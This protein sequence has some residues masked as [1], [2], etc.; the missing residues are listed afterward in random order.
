MKDE[1]KHSIQIK[2]D[3]SKNYN[4]HAATGA[5]GGIGHHG[6]IICH[7]YVEYQQFPDDLKIIIGE[8]SK[9]TKE[10][11]SLPDKF[12]REIQCTVVMRPDIAKSVAEWL[13]SN[14]N[15]ILIEEN[16]QPTKK[17]KK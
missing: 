13:L 9:I 14:V 10:D 11:R 15:K 12:V 7:F 3:K 6:E 17:A 4:M 1:K 8:N 16:L 5:W 2:F